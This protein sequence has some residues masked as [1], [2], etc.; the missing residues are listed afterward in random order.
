M[1]QVSEFVPAPRLIE[2]E[3]VGSSLPFVFVLIVESE[4]DECKFDCDGGLSRFISSS[5][6]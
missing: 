5:L 1:L 4:R 3:V 2:V 6:A